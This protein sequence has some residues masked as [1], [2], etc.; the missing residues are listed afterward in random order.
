MMG[1]LIG[2]GLRTNCLP[3]VK[4]PTLCRTALRFLATRWAIM[5][6]PFGRHLS[7]LPSHGAEGLDK[8]SLCALMVT[9]S[10]RPPCNAGAAWV[11]N[12]GRQ[13][14]SRVRYL[15]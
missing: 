9:Q 10:T 7:L 1:V 2:G 5:H 11:G 15:T 4:K 3:L 8:S 12:Q 6:V 14:C 13:T